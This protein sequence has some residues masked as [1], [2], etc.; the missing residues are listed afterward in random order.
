[1]NNQVNLLTL[2]QLYDAAILAQFDAA[3]IGL[4][5]NIPTPGAFTELGDITAATF[6][7]YASV[8]LQNVVKA[9]RANGLPFLTADQANWTVGPAQ[10]TQET[11]M[12]DYVFEAGELRG[13]RMYD[14]P[15]VVQTVGQVI[16]VTMDWAFGDLAPS[17]LIPQ[18]T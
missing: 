18:I 17:E 5:I 13:W 12:G 1:M 6:D 9:V 14:T 10:A 11:I 4:F 15:I 2:N 16:K 3:S 7:G 8:A